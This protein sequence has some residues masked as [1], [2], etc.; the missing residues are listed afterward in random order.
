MEV[1]RESTLEIW[2]NSV[3][4]ER[5]ERLRVKK[6]GAKEGFFNR[7]ETKPNEPQKLNQQHLLYLSIQIK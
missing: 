4:I 1:E 6:R 3:D 2:V 7:N 5:V